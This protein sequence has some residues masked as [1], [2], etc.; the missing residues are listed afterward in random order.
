MGV[1]PP[2]TQEVVRALIL[3]IYVLAVILGTLPLYRW[4]RRRGIPHNVA[5]YYNR[6]V[7]HMA[8]GGVIAFLT[9]WLFHE[10]FVPSLM[11]FALGAFLYYW[12]WRGRLLYWFQTEENMYEVNF[13]VAWGLSL[14]L[15]WL[16]TD[17]PLLA[18]VPA[19][20]ISF[21][22]GVTGVIRNAL[23]ARRTKHWAGNLGM[24]LVVVPLGYMLAGW[25]GALAGLV[26]SVVERFEFPPIDDNILIAV[27]SL[28]VLLAPAII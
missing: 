22:D 17:N 2:S 27:S 7:I 12:H 10:P 19:V 28:L 6:K 18:V 11:A 25:L 9:P 1:E 20:F 4:M 13:T 23:F 21:G 3:A 14:L 5:V 15:I 26:A 16:A 8:A 24:L